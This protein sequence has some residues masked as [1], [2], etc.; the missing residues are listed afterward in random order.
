MLSYI[1]S[2]EMD[3]ATKFLLQEASRTYKAMSGEELATY[4]M[5]ADFQY[6]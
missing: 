3:I 2:P 5:V 6:F 4:V 1:Y